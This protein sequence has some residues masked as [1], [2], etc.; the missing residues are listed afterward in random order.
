M[1]SLLP[2]KSMSRREKDDDRTAIEQALWE[3][4]DRHPADPADDHEDN[5]RF[6]ESLAQDLDEHSTNMEKHSRKAKKIAEVVKTIITTKKFAGRKVPNS[7]SYVQTVT[8]KSDT[9]FKKT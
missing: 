7:T 6:W 8:R 9:P 3:G 2:Y 1:K 5:R 4:Y